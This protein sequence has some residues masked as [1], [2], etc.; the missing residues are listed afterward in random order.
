MKFLKKLLVAILILLVL[1][2]TL[3]FVP[4]PK[5]TKTNPF[6]ST[7]GVPLVM[8][9]AGGKG[10][11]PDNTMAAYL[12]SYQ[13]GVDVL[14]M[15]VQLTK[16]KIPVLLHGQ[17]LTGNTI[18]HSNCDKVVWEEDYEDLYN[19]CNFGYTYQEDN[20]DFLYKDMSVQEWQ[21][22]K[23]YL[24]T[25]EEVFQTFG[26]EILYNI[27][28]K[29]D[30]DAPRNETA[31]AVIA[32]IENYQLED[33]VLLATA[34]DDISE[35]ILEEYPDIMLSMSYGSAIDT[36]VNIYTLTTVFRGKPKFAAM[37]VP[38]SYDLPVI[39]DFNVNRWGIIHGLD[40]QDVAIHFWTINDED[41]MRKLIKQGVDGIITDDPELLMSII[42]EYQTTD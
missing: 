26:N 19:Q 12:Y 40:Q 4:K 10:V 35:Y 14:E 33:H 32:L 11:Y 13:L 16:D 15:D 1:S 36:V 8:A 37:Q 5:Y 27:E 23:V 21:D 42:D 29:A 3:L 24:P 17:N 6:L 2:L 28:I 7:D 9:H 39:G 38:L 31:D 18:Q 34:F 30:A 20:G 25:L 41:T 22:A